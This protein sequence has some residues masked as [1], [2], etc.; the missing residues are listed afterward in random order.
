MERPE[1]L[2]A[3]LE[4]REDGNTLTL[5]ALALK[6]QV[7]FLVA[8]RA[9]SILVKAGAREM[10]DAPVKGSRW[11]IVPLRENGRAILPASSVKGAVRAR[12]KAIADLLGLDE[13]VTEELFG[14][15][16]RREESGRSGDNGLR[17]KICF[18]DVL[19]SDK[20]KEITRIRIN[21]FTGGVIRQGTFTEEPLQSA[22]TMRVTVPAE[23]VVGCGLLLYALRDLA[24]GLYSLGSGGAIGRGYL[25]VE[26]I[27]VQ[28]PDGTEA[29]LHFD[30]NGGCT[31]ED[32]NGLFARWLDA[33]RSDKV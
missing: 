14:R 18:E 27:R 25:A 10:R 12:V 3:W 5:P 22:V 20:G 6:S 17:G 8:G 16:N 2:Q 19:L 31:M 15:G 11:V 9:D 26:T 24:L 13:S 23:E 4:E 28:T 7:T 1:D 29:C 32:P 21:K 30:R 33:V